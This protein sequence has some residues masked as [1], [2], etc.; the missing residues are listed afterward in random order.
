MH[1]PQNNL[2]AGQRGRAR[3]VGIEAGGPLRQP[4]KKR[5]LRRRQHRGRGT[6]VG[7]ARALDAAD[8]V[9]VARE[10]QVHREQLPLREAMLE[11]D[12]D[13]RLMD[14]RP[15]SASTVGRLAIEEKLGDLL[16]NG[17]AALND[18]SLGEIGLH[19]TQDRERIDARMRPEATVLRRDGRRNQVRRQSVGR[20]RH[21]ARAIL[22]ARFIQRHAATVHHHRRGRGIIEQ[23]RRQRPKPQPQPG[24]AEHERRRSQ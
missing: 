23:P 15:P 21:S 5:R 10:V 16:R 3:L 24:D 12:R 4:G 7:A 9:A 8:L 17:G 19:R 6:E 1:A 13:H 2:L 22:R 11:A 20:Q 18:G 14:L